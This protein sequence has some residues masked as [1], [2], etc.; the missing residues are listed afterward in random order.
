MLFLTKQEGTDMDNDEVALR[1]RTTF[2]DA[3]IPIVFKYGV[4][5][6]LKFSTEPIFGRFMDVRTSDVELVS[7]GAQGHVNFKPNWKHKRQ[8]IW[9]VLWS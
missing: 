3:R 1:T 4:H 6:K 5:L 7:S 8:L 9:A 2:N